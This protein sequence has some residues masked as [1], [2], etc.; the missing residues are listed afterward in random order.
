AAGH[1]DLIAW[2]TAA[3]TVERIGVE[4]TGSYGS[5]L[6]TAL[7][8]Q[9]L[10]VVDV[11]RPDRR[12]RRF[13]GKS[14]PLDA[15]SAARAALT[16]N[17]TTIPKSHDGTVEAIRFLH[18]ARHSAVKARAEAITQL[19]SMI[20]NAP[21][22]IRTDLRQL[23]DA[24]LFAACASLPPAARRPVDLD[25]AVGAAL[26]SVALR[27]QDLTAEER[28]LAIQIEALVAAHAPHLL[29]RFGVG[30]STAAQLLITVG[31]NPERVTSEGSFARLCG[32]APIPASSGKTQRHR[33]D[34]G[35]DRQANRALYTIAITRLRSDERTQQ[36][37]DRRLAEGKTPRE[38]TRCLK[39][40]IARE[41]FG[42]LKPTPSP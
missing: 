11:D 12:S 13:Q 23:T 29:A 8:A 31:D 32:V 3:G 16:G 7:R 6:S 22:P 21:D 18:N 17:A 28:I 39:R 33:L 1:A 41:I 25:S 38:I 4:G 2:I 9:D 37:R 15:R 26:R 14:D 24:K 19:K 20:V 40:A 27:I 10:E 30:A 34:R 36:Y 35:G 5:T 42:L